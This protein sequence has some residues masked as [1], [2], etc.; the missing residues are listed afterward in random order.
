MLT[1]ETPIQELIEE[2]RTS[3]KTPYYLIDETRLVRNLEKIALLRKRAGVRSVLALKCFSTW[4]VFDLMRRYLDGTTSSSLYEARLGYERFG[5]EVHAYSVAFSDDEIAA[6]RAYASKIIFNSVS[7]LERFSPQ[8]TGMPLGLRI[9]PGVSY[10]PFDL[11]DPAREFCRL[12]ASDRGR[13]EGVSHL[14]SGVMFHCNC[15]N[16]DFEG[17]CSILE[18]IAREF[19]PLLRKMDWVSLGGGISF[20]RDDYPYDA[21]CKT[22]AAFSRRFQVQVYLEPGAAVV[23]RSGYLVTQVLD[24]VHN[25]KDIAIVDASLEAHMLDFL[26]YR[27]DA[28]IEGP[29]DGGR[30]YTV[31]G[32]SCLAGDVFGT[33][34]FPEELRVGTL[35]PFS[36]AA[37]YTMV[38]KNWFNGV[39]MPSI[40]VRRLDGRVDV[41]RTFDYDD[42]LS[43]VS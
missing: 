18:H 14:I 35:I 12:G 33:Y 11:A 37:D 29:Q 21:F 41:V 31:A 23:A 6:V 7:Q 9:N 30:S 40:V 17:V 1:T 3:L 16:A 2:Y 36:D 39:A 38:K 8:L 10:S 22:L 27:M 28:R 43:S 32:R 25:G 34:T 4:S 26:I 20:T 42:F 19:G 5:K 13:I 24:I 15:D